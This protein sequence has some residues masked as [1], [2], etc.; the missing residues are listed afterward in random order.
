MGDSRRSTAVAVIVVSLFAGAAFS[1]PSVSTITPASG[2]TRGGEIVHIHGTGLLGAPLACPA[3]QCSVYLKF[4]DVYGNVISDAETEIVVVA[5]PHAAGVVDL[6][7]NVPVNPP[8]TLASA[9]SYQQPAADDLV[10]L[11]VPIAINAAGAGGSQWQTDLEVYNGNAEA[12]PIAGTI[13]APL[14][15]A[16]LTLHPPPGSAGTFVAVPKRLADN[17][18]INARVHDTTR[19]ADSWGVEVPAVPESQFRRSVVLLAVPADARYR[20]LLRVYGYDASDNVATVAVRDDATGELLDTRTLL[21]RSGYGQLF[22]SAA[23]PRLR[24][25]VTAASLIWAFASITNNTTQQVTTITPAFATSAVAPPTTLPIG[26]WGGNGICV[27]VTGTTTQVRAGCCGG[28]FFTPAPGADGRFEA[29]GSFGC[30]IGPVPPNPP[31]GPPA[32]L[33]GVVQGTSMA[34]TIRT[35]TTTSGPWTVQFGDLTPCTPPCP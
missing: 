28:S 33:S 13:V 14:A 20:V 4:G 12:L 5:P 6:Q 11:L 3:I 7:I 15:T 29:D 34:L 9:Y 22:V 31:P 8:I 19:D 30:S 16:A 23:R 24:V 17:V 25:E 26:H 35:A 2:L 32:H 21:L 27:E 1:A 10:R 18:G